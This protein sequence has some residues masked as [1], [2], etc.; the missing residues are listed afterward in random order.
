ML[1]SNILEAWFVWVLAMEL[2][3][4]LKSVD[5]VGSKFPSPFTDFVTLPMNK[6]FLFLPVDAKIKDLKDF[7]F[8]F[9]INFN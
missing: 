6:I 8:L 7:K 3:K 9:A 4:H 5:K 1:D 2:L